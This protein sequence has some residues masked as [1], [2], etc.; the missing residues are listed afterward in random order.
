MD[1]LKLYGPPG[2]GKTYSG[3]NWLVRQV[4]EGVDIQR[5]AF[6]SFTNAACD[7]ARARVCDRFGVAPDDV[8]YCATLHALA[9][10]ALGIQGKDWLAGDKLDEFAKAYGYDLKPTKK[11]RASDPDDMGSVA[12]AEGRDAPLLHVWHFGRNRLLTDPGECMRAYQQYDPDGALMI[13]F[14]RFVQFVKDYEA[15]KEESDRYD[16][17]DLLLLA[18]ERQCRVPAMAA[19]VD[20]CQDLSALLWAAADTL[21]A[22]TPRRAT[23]GDDDQALYGFQGATPEL[24]N[25]RPAREVVKLELSHRLPRRVAALA[26]SIIDRN[27]N[28]TAKQITPRDEEGSVQRAQ[29]ADLEWTNGE[30]WFVLVRNWHFFKNVAEN[31]EDLGVPYRCIGGRKYSPWSEHGPLK[32]ARAI[33]RLGDGHRIRL[34]EL[35]TVVDRTPSAVGQRAGAW[36]YGAKTRVE[37]LA[38]RSPGATVGLM[39][40][41]RLGLT[42]TAFDAIVDRNLGLLEG[43]VSE[44]D[45]NAY[46]RALARGNWERDVAVAVGSM[47]SAKGREADNVVGYMACTGAP[48]RSLTR[49]QRREEEHR[50]GYVTVTRARRNFYAVPAGLWDGGYPYEVFGL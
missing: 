18:V 16:Y 12:E 8:P 15:W 14:P 13:E 1:T 20:E 11:R 29:L 48:M 36:V 7:E 46:A 50:I 41:P 42:A 30:S 40:L 23:L 9:K 4:E 33:R 24:M 19:A 26:R 35:M 3:I 6:V 44:R 2:T 28:R 39:D 17:T 38:R 21:F 27:Q 43:H 5:A 47:H 22:D 49:P 34:A 31:L 32:A 25:Q 37:G 45:R 10:R